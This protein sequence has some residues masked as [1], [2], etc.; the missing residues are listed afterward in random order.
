MS[1]SVLLHAVYGNLPPGL[2]EVPPRAQQC[3]PQVPGAAMLSALAPASCASMV[4][5]APAS[6]V[7]RRH[8]L[9]LALRALVQDGPLTVLAVNDKGGT[10]IADELAALGCAVHQ[11]SK[12]HHRIVRTHRP[13]VSAGLDE[14]IAAGQPQFLPDL[15]LWSQPGLFN[16]DRI[17]PGSQLLINHLPPLAGRGADLGCGI[18]VLARAIRRDPAAPL[19][20]IDIDGR[21]LDMA[22]ENVPGDGVTTLWTDVRTARDLPSGLDYVVMNPPFHDGGAEDRALGQVFIQQAA[23]MLRPGG[24]LWMTANRHLPYEATLTPL[25]DTVDVIDQ[26]KGFKIFAAQKKTMS[27]NRQAKDGEGSARPGSTRS[28]LRS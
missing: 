19:T 2:A 10:R 1:E 27:K 26:A 24:M 25:F 3:S 6:T 21:A 23:A 15:K 17:D 13:A 16:W 7:E 9:A 5:H 14:A 20:L 28:K 11:S 8:V 4:M 12:R 18:G 22:R